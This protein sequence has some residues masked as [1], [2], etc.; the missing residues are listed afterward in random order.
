M[1]AFV[2]SNNHINSIVRWASV[3][4]IAFSYGPN[5]I[6][7]VPG[8]EDATAQMLLD[9]N[10]RSVNFRYKES[11]EPE[12]IKFQN[13]APMLTPMGVLKAIH[14]LEYQSCET[15]EWERTKAARLLATI[16]REAIYRLPGY[17]E[18]KYAIY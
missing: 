11:T 18:A 13:T 2:V 17:E 14:C 10:V 15:D 3:N 1:S 4:N 12:S 7:R 5:Q 16:E 6:W 8:N 9:E